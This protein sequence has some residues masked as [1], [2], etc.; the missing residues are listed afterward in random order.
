M[1]KVL[2]SSGVS[3][4]IAISKE[5]GK[6]IGTSTAT[7]STAAVSST[8][9]TSTSTLITAATATKL[10]FAVAA[11]SIAGT[12]VIVAGSYLIHVKLSEVKCKNCNKT[13]DTEGCV[14]KC[15]NCKELL[16]TRGCE[17][18]YP[19]CK[20]QTEEAIGCQLREKCIN[21][22]CNKEEGARNFAAAVESLKKIQDVNYQQIMTQ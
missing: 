22:K 13:L 10:A 14:K 17:L 16:S 18:R 6:G 2:C 9:T 15:E 11:A 20:K 12:A 3:G 8:A 19:C 1:I 7:V 4:G 5:I 21:N